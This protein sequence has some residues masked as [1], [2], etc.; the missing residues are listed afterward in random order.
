MPSICRATSRL[1]YLDQERQDI[2]NWLSPLN[3]NVS[4]SEAFHKC[5]DGTGQWL[6]KSSQFEEWR[7]GNLQTIGV[8]EFVRSGDC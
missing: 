2:L 1:F 6:L 3:F 4:Q 8:L 7:D 5:T